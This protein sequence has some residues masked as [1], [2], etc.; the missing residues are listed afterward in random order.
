VRFLFIDAYYPEFVEET[1]RLHKGLA[2]DP[3]DDQLGELQDGLFG[4]A[5]FQVAALRQLGHEADMVITNAHAAQGA[6]AREH[7]IRVRGQRAIGVRMRRGLIPWPT[8]VALGT[9]WEIVLAQA[10]AYRP[11]VL[12][13][14]IMDS[15]PDEI[16][17][18]VARFARF[19]VAQI[20]APYS[21]TSYRGYDLLI[22]SI[23]GFVDRFRREGADAVLIPLAFDPS[24]LNSV[25]SGPRDVSVSF[26]GSLGSTHP[27]RLSILEQLSAVIDVDI[28]SAGG[29]FIRQPTRATLHGPAFGRAMYEV[30][31]R[32]R[33][34]LNV[35]AAWA[36]PDA[37]NLRLFEATGM[38][39]T[40]VTD[41]ARNM[42]D[43]FASGTEV[44]TYR[45]PDEAAEVVRDLLLHPKESALIASAGQ[46]RTL[47]DHTWSARMSEL[48]E[49]LGDR[50]ISN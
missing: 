37:N 26:V 1:Y 16:R 29:N 19:S 41:G 3:Y 50:G 21:S 17:R 34:T 47:R 39:A 43:L 22:S 49:A 35:H 12:Y 48:L 40:L 11:D 33:I 30:L 2:G 10:R 42:R 6:W 45:S 15:I 25:Q 46:A 4:E 27:E 44:V 24:V 36:R 18:E 5:Q 8:S 32:S 20:A 14:E 13:V 38:G 7:G 28:W 31:G 23:P 9:N